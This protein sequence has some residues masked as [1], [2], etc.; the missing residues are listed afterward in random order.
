[1]H[2]VQSDSKVLLVQSDPQDRK[3][4]LEQRG[5]SVRPARLEQWG[6]QVR[7]ALPVFQDLLG[8]PA[9][10]ALLGQRV[11]PVRRMRGV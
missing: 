9:R 1:M 4:R 6:L 10:S 5:L 8:P 7:L 2:K 3:A 11:L